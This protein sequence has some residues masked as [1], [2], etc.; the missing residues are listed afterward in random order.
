[1]ILGMSFQLELVGKG[2][3]RGGDRVSKDREVR[4]CT[5]AL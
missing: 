5:R 3:S 4:K 1:M 2:I